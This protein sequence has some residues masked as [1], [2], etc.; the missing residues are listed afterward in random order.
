[1]VRAS[2]GHLPL[3][4][5]TYFHRGEDSPEGL[6]ILVWKRL[7]EELE[8]VAGQETQSRWMDGLWVTF[9]VPCA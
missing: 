2:P 1:M 7:W 8:S 5:S 6:H 9:C 4:Y 3:R